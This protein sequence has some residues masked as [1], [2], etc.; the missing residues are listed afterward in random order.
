MA[1]PDFV[2][3]PNAPGP[4]QD[5][6]RQ[7]GHLRR[8][9]MAQRHVAPGRLGHPARVYPVAGRS[10]PAITSSEPARAASHLKGR[11]AS[12]GGAK[13]LDSTGA[14]ATPPTHLPT[15]FPEDPNRLSPRR[16]A[17][18]RVHN[19][20]AGGRCRQES[21]FRDS[22]RWL[23]LPRQPRR[24]AGK[25]PRPAPRYRAVPGRRGA[26]RSPAGQAVSFIGRLVNGRDVW[27]S[28]RSRRP[29]GRRSRTL[30]GHQF[31]ESSE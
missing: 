10:R 30:R 24:H 16:Q 8:A 18:F 6:Q 11:S 7:A 29:A 23:V 21:P 20:I 14:E 1:L 15:R 2:W 25:R 28:P 5:G 31:R 13:R 9:P 17:Q 12:G 26:S 4:S 22:R 27:L 19:P 3:A